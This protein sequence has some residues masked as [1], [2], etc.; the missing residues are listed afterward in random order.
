M[1]KYLKTTQLSPSPINQNEDELLTRPNQRSLV[2]TQSYPHPHSS[3]NGEIASTS[4]SRVSSD[5]YVPTGKAQS[6]ST[7]VTVRNPLSPTSTAQRL[8]HQSQSLL[9]SN[10]QKPLVLFPQSMSPPNGPPSRQ[11]EDITRVENGFLVTTQPSPKF[12]GTAMS[13]RSKSEIWEK[14]TI[15]SNTA[16][17][18]ISNPKLLFEFGDELPSAFSSPSQYQDPPRVSSMTNEELLNGP[19]NTNLTAVGETSENSNSGG[20]LFHSDN[21]VQ[22]HRPRLDSK[23]IPYVEE[24]LHTLPSTQS[25]IEDKAGGSFPTSMSGDMLMQ[26]RKYEDPTM[27]ASMADALAASTRFYHSMMAQAEEGE[28]HYTPFSRP[29]YPNKR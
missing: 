29:T 23:D 27:A 11:A 4:L 20:G 13:G 12:H 6:V 15:C 8:S 16:T 24:E 22:L 28:H 17:S 19:E 21:C 25:S 9:L 26:S 10:S 3:S 14:D 5:V 18:C 1:K 7:D 2:N